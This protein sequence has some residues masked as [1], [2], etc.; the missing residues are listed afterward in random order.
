MN[1]IEKAH[2]QLGHIRNL[3]YYPSLRGKLNGV[4]LQLSEGC[5]HDCDFCMVPFKGS[6]NSRPKK[7]IMK[8]IFP[9]MGKPV[10]VVYLDDKTFG[11]ADNWNILSTIKDRINPDGFVVQTT[12]LQVVN[13]GL[14]ALNEWKEAGVIAVEIGVESFNNDILK[15][16][17]KPA[18][19]ILITEAV[20]LLNEAEIPVCPNIIIGMK[21]ETRESYERTA[22]WMQSVRGLGWFNLYCLADYGTKSDAD[23]TTPFKSWQNDDEKRV[24]SF[25]YNLIYTT[26]IERGI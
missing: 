15:R 21:G 24:A 16:Y 23:E 26:A 1:D 18:R 9:L 17:R 3:S 7:S 25:G 10:G 4:R 11:Q 22:K 6:V 5:L 8:D 14:D 20:S 12:A 13:M 19:Q 2:E